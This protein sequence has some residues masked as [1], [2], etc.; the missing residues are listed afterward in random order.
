MHKSRY[1]S[2]E[3]YI[4]NHWYNRREYNDM[5]PLYDE[6]IYERLTEHGDLDISIPYW[7]L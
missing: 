4:S 7:T 1:E 6:A 2:V 5:K 3:R